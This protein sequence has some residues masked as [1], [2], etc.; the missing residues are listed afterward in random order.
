MTPL[1][2][3]KNRTSILEKQGSTKTVLCTTGIFSEKE[4]KDKL[5]E[6]YL[7]QWKGAIFTAT[8][9]YLKSPINTPRYSLKKVDELVTRTISHLQKNEYYCQTLRRIFILKALSFQ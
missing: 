4:E 1:A 2:K 9:I 3:D 6:Y 8:V 7:S 5:F